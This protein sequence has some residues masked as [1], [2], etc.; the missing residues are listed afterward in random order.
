VNDVAIDAAALATL[1]PGMLVSALRTICGPNWDQVKPDDDGWV[2]KLVDIGFTARIDVNGIIGK[3]GFTGKFPT[4]IA[5]D[6]LQIGMS[7]DAALVA[8]PTLHHIE[9]VTISA[10]TLRRFG[11]TRRDGIEIEARFRDGR[12]V[13][14]DLER[15]GAIYRP[16]S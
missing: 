16:A 11:A 9:D 13:A 6:L 3:I 14:F 5:V 1:R 15:P 10:M 4:T 12:L 8:Y 2:V 7:F